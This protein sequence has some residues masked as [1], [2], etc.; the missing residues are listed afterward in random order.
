MDSYIVKENNMQIEE[1]EVM[2][3]NTIVLTVNIE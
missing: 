1:E 3:D 2:E